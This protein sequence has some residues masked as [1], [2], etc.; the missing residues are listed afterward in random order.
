MSRRETDIVTTVCSLSVRER[1][2]L[3][4]MKRILGLASDANLI[5]SSLWFYARHL[6]LP[7]QVG[8]FGLRMPGRSRR[9]RRPA[10][11]QSA[12]PRRPAPVTMLPPRPKEG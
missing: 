9:T 5:R 2:I 1:L 6:D 7:V 8:D 3:D 11:K 4:D 12:V 10:G